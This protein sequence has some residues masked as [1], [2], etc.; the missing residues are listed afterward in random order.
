M[1]ADEI[2]KKAGKKPK[3]GDWYIN[4]LLNELSK[5]QTKE[6]PEDNI[7]GLAERNMYFFSYAAQY[8]YR[9]EFWDRQPLVY[10]LKIEGGSFVGINLHYIP[11]DFR[12]GYALG[13]INKEEAFQIPPKSFHRY[14]FSG[15]LGGFMRVPKREWTSVVKLPTEKFVDGRGQPFPKHRAWRIT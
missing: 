7:G 15:V 10:V 11:P 14:F 5:F 8:S 1:I 4:S 12:E 3:S 13:L 6:V 9:Y 2:L